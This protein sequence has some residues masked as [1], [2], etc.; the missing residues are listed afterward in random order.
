MIKVLIFLFLTLGSLVSAPT[1]FAQCPIC[2]VTVGG[3]MLIAKKLGVDDLLVSLWISGLN[4]AISFWLA[5]GMKDKALKPRLLHNPWLLSFLMLLLTLSYFQFTGQLGH[6][7]N[8]ILGWDKIL[9]GQTLGMLAMFLGNFVYGYTK[10][11]NG[12]RTLFPYAKV[13]FPLGIL[14]VVTLVFKLTFHL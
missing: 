1:T 3:G 6:P 12:N 2:V 7:S 11:R 9:L 14:T 4:T 13:V 10:Y 5:N 8:K